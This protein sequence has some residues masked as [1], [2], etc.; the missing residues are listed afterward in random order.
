MYY[1][2]P[3]SKFSINLATVRYK[4]MQS[5]GPA[6]VSSRPQVWPNLNNISDTMRSG[7][8]K[9]LMHS[10]GTGPRVS[11]SEMI[12]CK[13]RAELLREIMQL[14]FCTLTANKLAIVKARRRRKRIQ[15]QT[16]SETADLKTRDDSTFSLA[17]PIGYVSQSTDVLQRCH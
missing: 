7:P 2:V 3:Q 11:H 13:R 14:P 17:P 9:R 8:S 16:S 12:Q 4:L 1:P 5:K 6:K 15:A 10:D